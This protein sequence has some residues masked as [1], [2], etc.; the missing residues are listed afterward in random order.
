MLKEV[1]DLL[2]GYGARAVPQGREKLVW[3]NGMLLAESGNEILLTGTERTI[4][5]TLA[6]K[7]NEL[8][9]QTE[10]IEALVN[11]GYTIGTHTY[12][13]VILHRLRKKLGA[14]DSLIQTERDNGYSLRVYDDS[15]IIR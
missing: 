3:S 8:I 5:A 1:N 4:F 12:F 11:R 10:L 13:R 2:R 9:S 14:N 15:L 6:G 7:P